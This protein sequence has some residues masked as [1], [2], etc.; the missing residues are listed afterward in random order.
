[1]SQIHIKRAHHLSS[2]DAKERLEGIARDMQEKLSFDYQWKGNSLHVKRPGATGV[3]EL[4][5]GFIDVRLKLGM[6]L[7]PMKGRIKESIEENIRTSL[8]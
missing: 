3:I 2:E 8:V 7:A 4:G 6:M 1:M 5:D